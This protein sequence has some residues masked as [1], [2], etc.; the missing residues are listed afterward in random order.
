MPFDFLNLEIV[1]SPQN[2]LLGNTGH[3][4]PYTFKEMEDGIY[5]FI[6]KHLKIEGKTEKDTNVEIKINNESKEIIRD[7]FE[8]SIITGVFEIDIN[9]VLESE[10]PL[11]FEMDSIGFQNSRCVRKGYNFWDI[12]QKKGS[13]WISIVNFPKNDPNETNTLRILIKEIASNPLK[14][15]LDLIIQR[16]KPNIKTD[17]LLIYDNR[18]GI[19][20]DSNINRIN[21]K[22]K[23]NSEC[24]NYTLHIIPEPKGTIYPL[25][26]KA[27][28]EI[29]NFLI[30]NKIIYCKKCSKIISGSHVGELDDTGGVCYFHIECF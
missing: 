20:T 2:F 30:N 3:Y 10:I 16:I 6:E 29:P 23:P 28:N 1:E 27:F 22:N 12:E 4:E 19:K 9:L 18:P 5:H 8:K 24:K 26:N 21:L 7:L 25:E 17:S 14:V 11:L 13:K 15:E